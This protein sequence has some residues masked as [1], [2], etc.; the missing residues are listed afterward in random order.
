MLGRRVS[1][2]HV[3]SRAAGIYLHHLLLVVVPAEGA[4]RRLGFGGELQHGPIIG[5]GSI[6]S[7]FG[8]AD[9][10]QA[11]NFERHDV[12]TRLVQAGT[13]EDTGRLD[14]GGA[15]IGVWSR[16]GIAQKWWMV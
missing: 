14:M 2:V 12:W 8:I 10:G 16:T 9:D 4:F 13:E 6:A 15:V 3:T 11:D 1:D 5:L 7:I